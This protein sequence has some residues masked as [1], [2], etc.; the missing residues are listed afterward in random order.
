MLKVKDICANNCYFIRGYYFQVSSF[1]HMLSLCNFLL[2]VDRKRACITYNSKLPATRCLL[3]LLLMVLDMA[4][5]ASVEKGSECGGSRSN[6]E[7]D[8]HTRQL[9]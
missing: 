4:A 5:S 1:C 9:R 8:S 3:K 6:G 2:W 7:Q